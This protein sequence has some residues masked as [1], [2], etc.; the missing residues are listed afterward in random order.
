MTVGVLFDRRQTDSVHPDPLCGANLKGTGR[1]QRGIKAR[2]DAF[3]AAVRLLTD[4]GAP[5]TCDG[6]ADS[7]GQR[8]TQVGACSL[9]VQACTGINFLHVVP[10][11]TF[12]GTRSDAS[13]GLP[14]LSIDH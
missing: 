12:R 9:S 3:D 2:P 8:G 6:C 11:S 4:R 10:P 13:R 1:V 5:V 7:A 14:R